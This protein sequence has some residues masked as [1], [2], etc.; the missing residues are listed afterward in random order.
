[1]H[2][3]M[4]THVSMQAAALRALCRLTVLSEPLC[5]RAVQLAEAG[6]SASS[7]GVRQAAVEVLADT[8][9]AYPTGFGDR[10]LLVGQLMLPAVAGPGR[11]AEQAQQPGAGS[12]AE[13]PGNDRAGAPA[14]SARHRSDQQQQMAR[15]AAAAY[16]RLLLR[17]KLKLQG[18]LSPVGAALAGGSPPVAALVRHALRQMLAAGAAALRERSRL[19]MDLFHQTPPSC[20]AQLAEVRGRVGWE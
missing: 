8:I 16:C 1:M 12:Q 10:L 9:D 4:H 13:V 17:N 3:H 7:P 20:R 14:G 11:D 18:V 6:L 15:A 2:V 5:R 19:C